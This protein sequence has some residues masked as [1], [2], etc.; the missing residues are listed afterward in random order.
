MPHA[1][2][3]PAINKRTEELLQLAQSDI[4]KSTDRMF[5]KLMIF[6]WLFGILI[7]FII[8]PQAWEGSQSAVH[9]HL[10]AAIFLGGGIFILPV[11][12]GIF[13]PGHTYTRYSIAVAQMLY[14]GLLIH[15]TGGRIETHFHIFGSLAFLAF[16]RDWKVLIIATVVTTLDHWLRGVYWP[17]S[18]FG[19]LTAGP[20][21]WV[22][23]AGWVVFE[24]IVLIRTCLR[25][26]VEMRKIAQDKA[27][28]ETKNEQLSNA[29][30]ELQSTYKQLMES[31]K[32]EAKLQM[33]NEFTSTVSHELRTPLASIK[34]SIDIVMSGSAGAVTEDQNKFLSKAKS[35]IDRLKRLIDDFLD[36]SKLESGMVKLELGSTHIQR[37]VEEVIELHKPVAAKKRVTLKNNMPADLP[38]VSCDPDRINQVL[39]NLINNAIKFTDKGEIAVSAKVIAE[40][41]SIQICVQDTG[42]GMK[43][44]DVAKIFEK[45]QQVGDPLKRK[46]GGTGLG[47]AIC[48]QIVHQHGG[49]IWVESQ[50]G[51]GSRFYFSLSL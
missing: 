22:E 19:V 50:I 44:E 10:L 5:V 41:K 43:Q 51:E 15:L 33:Q 8:S 4:Y 31:E 46:T 18:I 24:V 45:F 34:G 7:A 17:L 27:E 20:F 2:V 26:L 28:L 16:Y 6:Q 40:K 25:S 3:T 39:T 42:E 37:I 35:N 48:K 12:F 49:E 38:Q 30:N 47:L 21:R 9:T 29:M 32:L 11:L 13:K 1:L 14:S 23:H 36:F